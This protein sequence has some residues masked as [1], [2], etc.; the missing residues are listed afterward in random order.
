MP[1]KKCAKNGKS[2]WKFGDSGKC[3][4]GPGAREKARKQG[5]AIKISESK[6]STIDKVSLYLK[7][8]TQESNG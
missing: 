4:T 7:E 2:G 1:L 8:V 5:A 6:G 3:F